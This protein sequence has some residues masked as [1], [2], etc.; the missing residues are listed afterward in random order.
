[1]I[2]RLFYRICSTSIREARKN[3]L[4][5]KNAVL[6]PCYTMETRHEHICVTTFTVFNPLFNSQRMRRSPCS[7][8]GKK[9]KPSDLD[10][11]KMFDLYGSRT[12]SEL[13][14]VDSLDYRGLDEGIGDISYDATCG[15]LGI[16][17]PSSIHLYGLSAGQLYWHSTPI[18]L[19]DTFST[20]IVAMELHTG[21][22]HLVFDEGKF[23]VYAVFTLDGKECCR[24]RVPAP[25]HHVELVVTDDETYISSFSTVH[26]FDKCGVHKNII[27]VYP[28]N[29]VITA[30][31][32][33]QGQIIALQ[34]YY[35]SVVSV[36]A[37]LIKCGSNQDTIMDICVHDNMIFRPHL[38]E[39]KVL[40][41]PL[42]G[43]FNDEPVIL[44]TKSI[45][46]RIVACENS[47]FAL[48]DDRRVELY[49]V[50]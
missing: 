14:L 34:Y 44:G 21:F 42:S 46:N 37:E 16:Q 25:Q 4:A 48:T 1:M 2:Q 6:H 22:I 23:N 13:N 30:L 5:K 26:R 10:K 9:R 8:T 43:L 36:D 41:T 20:S 50:N 15:I 12:D 35:L 27:D 47:L 39:K 29:S 40:M 11:N 17:F 18:S 38:R 33:W 3:R 19:V 28:F 31:Q 24:L 32:Y 7:N 49:T 45:L